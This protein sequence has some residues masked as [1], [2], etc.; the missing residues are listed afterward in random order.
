MSELVF[1]TDIGL[2]KEK[3]ESRGLLLII[4]RQRSIAI[5]EY[6]RRGKKETGK[7]PTAHYLKPTQIVRLKNLQAANR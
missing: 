2:P 6:L 5:G 3:G 1:G 7:H 4:G